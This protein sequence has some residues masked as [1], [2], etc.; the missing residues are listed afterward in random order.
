M[1]IGRACVL[2]VGGGGGVKLGPFGVELN[3]S[4]WWET[5]G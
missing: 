5:V 2:L 4:R 1:L 3:A